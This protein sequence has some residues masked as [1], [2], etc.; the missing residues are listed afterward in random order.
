MS[1]GDFISNGR[2]SKKY[3]LTPVLEDDEFMDDYFRGILS[4]Y[5]PEPPSKEDEYRSKKSSETSGVMDRR[6][7]RKTD[8][9]VYQPDLFLGDM[10]KD[11]RSLMDSA[12][13]NGFR[14]FMEHRKDALKINL[15]NDDDK[16]IH[17]KTMTHNESRKKKDEVFYRVKKKYTNF[18]DQVINTKPSKMLS[19]K[20]IERN[21]KSLAEYIINSDKKNYANFQDY[22]KH[23]SFQNKNNGD[24][25]SLQNSDY[26]VDEKANRFSKT[27]DRKN[28]GM[29]LSKLNSNIR[30]GQSDTVDSI[31][32]QILNYGSKQSIKI[33]SK[34]AISISKSIENNKMFKNAE[35]IAGKN[36]ASSMTLNSSNFNN[37][38]K[39][40]GLNEFRVN[41]NFLKESKSN[42]E[43]FG[44]ERLIQSRI[45]RNKQ[46]APVIND[47][48]LNV[49]SISN[50]DRAN[51]SK[52][53]NTNMSATI[54]SKNGSQMISSIKQ[55]L[56]MSNFSG[57][58]NK[59]KESKENNNKRIST[60]NVPFS[61][62][63]II[64][65]YETF[66]D[67]REGQL[68][69]NK[70]QISIYNYKSKKPV[71]FE[72]ASLLS[73]GEI[74]NQRNHYKSKDNVERGMRHSAVKYK[75]IGMQTSR[76][77]GDMS[78][79]TGITADRISVKPAGS[80]GVI[81]NKFIR[82][83]IETDED[84]SNKMG[85]MTSF[86]KTY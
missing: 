28:N 13:L 44:V 42:K 29:N 43:S 26:S 3:E 23:S 72:K 15:L 75:Q 55:S 85:E 81:G 70:E 66:K 7:G 77:A 47:S 38:G 14:K 49:E 1:R 50:K 31:D 40:S 10:S 36:M 79:N 73:S 27:K 80:A 33:T 19:Q 78:F 24:R 83:K 48:R 9:S 17:S 63:S 59:I 62:K 11:P 39:Q 69:T 86:R 53:N 46:I 21:K 30:K 25:K 71:F 5:T 45:S 12:D 22:N 84:E 8:S 67:T 51:Y 32:K 58:N 20:E 82:H 16:S 34:K 74:E 18:E 65:N 4:D 6:Y 76:D 61:R 68:G 37:S 64:N 35:Q 60:K 2:I 41:N 54:L 57:D 56:R 52:I